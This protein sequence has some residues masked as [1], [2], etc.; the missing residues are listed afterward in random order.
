MLPF[1]QHML[2]AL[3]AP[4]PLYVKSDALDEWADP[5]ATVKSV[6]LASA[7]YELYD[8]PGAILPEIIENEYP[9]HDGTIAYHCDCGDHDLNCFDWGLYMNFADRFLK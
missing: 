6:R 9:Y 3:M 5:E 1:D 2:L 4:R 7:A 8:K